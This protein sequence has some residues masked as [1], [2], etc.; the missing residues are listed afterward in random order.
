MGFQPTGGT[1]HGRELGEARSIG[2]GCLQVL[3]KERAPKEEVLHTLLL[4]AEAIVNSP[5]L[6]Y[7]STMTS[8]TCRA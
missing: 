7:V 2:Q 1:P 3:L 4:E 5:P 6:T 8:M